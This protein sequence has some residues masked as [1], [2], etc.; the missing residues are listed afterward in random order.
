MKNAIIGLL[1][2]ILTVPISTGVLA[3]SEDED[4]DTS[5]NAPR[6]S[7]CHGD[8][9]PEESIMEID[10]SIQAIPEAVL[11][12]PTFNDVTTSPPWC[13]GRLVYQQTAL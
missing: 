8:P 12:L 6:G 13:P 5:S 1:S 11:E 3:Q 10:Q 4:A 7:H 2:A 9:S